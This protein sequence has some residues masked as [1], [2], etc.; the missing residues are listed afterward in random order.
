VDGFV[1]GGEDRAGFCGLEVGPGEG[2]H[3]CT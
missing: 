3:C 1:V 2:Q